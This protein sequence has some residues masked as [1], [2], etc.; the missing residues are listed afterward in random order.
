MGRF[1][2]LFGNTAFDVDAIAEAF[3][4]ANGF[5]PVNVLAWFNALV[6]PLL[7]LSG[8]PTILPADLAPAP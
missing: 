1:W 3:K 7:V 2:K 5:L 6:A 8:A 4:I